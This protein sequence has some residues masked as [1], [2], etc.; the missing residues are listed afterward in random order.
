LPQPV[1]KAARP[2][3]WSAEVQALKRDAGARAH[4][5]L[6]A[7]ASGEGRQQAPSQLL[8]PQG[9]CAAEGQLG[10]G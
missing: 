10:G 6:E 7:T 9:T 4:P 5:R 3:A 8:W 1:E 2:R